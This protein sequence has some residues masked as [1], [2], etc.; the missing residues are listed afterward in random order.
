MLGPLTTKE[1]SKSETFLI[2][3]VQS[4]EFEEDL[5]CL[6]AQQNVPH[7]SKIKNLN[8]FSDEEGVLRVNGRINHAN[9][10]FNSKFQIILPKGHKLTRLILEFYHKR[11]FHLGPTALLHYVRQKFWPVQGK[12]TCRKIVHDCIDCFKVKPLGVE[13]LMG[14][15]PKERVTPD[16]PFNCSDTDF[17]GP[18]FIK[19]KHQRKGIHHKIY[20]CIFVCLV[21]KAIHLGLV[22]DLTSNAFIASLKRF[23]ARRGLCSKLFSDNAT[24]FTAANKELTKLDNLVL[25]PDDCL[26]NYLTT[27]GIEWHFLPPRAPSFGGLWESGV[28]AFKFHFRR[29]VGNSRLSY[30]EFLT[31]TTQI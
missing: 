19:Y 28:K 7:K 31:V 12:A 16:F 3:N 13:Q 11:Y 8:P 18:F 17:C 4:I 29:V 24:N 2:K 27:E 5:K 20:V 1:R 21:T 9:V 22:T 23:V 26:A 14:N 30:E 25:K 10:E 15:L 6:R